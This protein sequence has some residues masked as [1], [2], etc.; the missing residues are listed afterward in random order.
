MSH[1][2]AL[3]WK[4]PSEFW[5]A[6]WRSNLADLRFVCVLCHGHGHGLFIMSR[7]FLVERDTFLRRRLED[8]HILDTHQVFARRLPFC[9]LL[10]RRYIY[11][12]FWMRVNILFVVLY[13]SSWIPC[14]NVHIYIYICIY[15]YIHTYIHIQWL[16]C[17]DCIHMR[18]PPTRC[19]NLA[20]LLAH[21]TFIQALIRLILTSI[22]RIIYI[23][24][25]THTYIYIHIHAHTY[26]RKFTC[27]LKC[28]ANLGP[29][30]G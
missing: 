8:L 12:C 16:T 18:T 19:V 4:V 6:R 20:S 13:S 21:I 5:Q 11:T 28:T 26:I 15:V 24:I 30:N 9:L 22:E 2:R 23:Y 10:A 3:R 27:I 29:G 1:Q 17:I 7:Y 14:M 25:H